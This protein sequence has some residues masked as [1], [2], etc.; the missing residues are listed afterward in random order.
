MC[1]GKTYIHTYVYISI[2]YKERSPGTYYLS[3]TTFDLE[4]SDS[5]TKEPL[6]A[7]STEHP[8]SS[9]R[10]YVLFVVSLLAFEQGWIWNTYGPIASVV[11]R[12]RVKRAVQHRWLCALYARFDL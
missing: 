11:E 1:C 3:I 2:A 12:D 9:K 4:M 8:V 6:L 7:E 5:R 10:W